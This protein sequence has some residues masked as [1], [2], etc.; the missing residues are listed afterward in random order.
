M[1]RGLQAPGLPFVC[2][3]LGVIFYPAGLVYTKAMQPNA[4][5]YGAAA[6]YNKTSGPNLGN[7]FKIAGIV[8]GAIV[9]I[10]VGFFVF[11]L[12]TSGSKNSAAQ[13]V[14]REKQL[15]S[16]VTTNQDSIA[17]DDFK[18]VNSHATNL[19]TSDGY[20]LQQ[21]LIALGLAAVP[22]QIAKAEADTTS[23]KTLATATSQNN[24]DAV[25]LELLREKIAATE[26]LARTVQSGTTG[27]M[28][29]AATTLLTNLSAIDE[30]LATLKF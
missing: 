26:S 13:L 2:T 28:Q 15:L 6:E 24:F 27:K 10:A 3:R 8:V 20:A 7:I 17:S 19:L 11:N 14:A 16:F 1:G 9:L 30:Q 4:K 29:A 12:I 23:A 21:G 5:F 18:T 22:E 25:Y